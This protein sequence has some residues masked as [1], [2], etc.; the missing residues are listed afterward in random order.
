MPGQ[1]KDRERVIA[2]CITHV[3]EVVNAV[4]CVCDQAGLDEIEQRLFPMPTDAEKA[5]MLEE[6]IHTL[7]RAGEAD[8][9]DSIKAVEARLMAL[10]AKPVETDEPKENKDEAT[11]T[12]RPTE[13]PG[14]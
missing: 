2:R 14:Q 3:R 12:E 8:D 7:K 6:I 10:A 11:E 5:A 13:T 9:S 4:E 1:F